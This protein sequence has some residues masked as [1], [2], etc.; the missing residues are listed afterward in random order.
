MLLLAPIVSSEGQIGKFEGIVVDSETDQRL[1]GATVRLKNS[2]ESVLTNQKGE[3]SLRVPF[4]RHDIEVTSPFYTSKTLTGIQVTEAQPTQII[5]VSLVPQIIPLAEIRVPIRFLQSSEVGM[6]DKRRRSRL[7]T[8]SMS[9]QWMSKISASD[10]GD[11]L[12]RVTGITIVGGRY[13]YVR[14]LGE[15]YSNTLLNNVEIPSPE[16]NRRVVPMDIFSANLLESIETVKTFSPDQPGSFSGGSVRIVTKEFPEALMMS[17]SA[18]MSTNTETTRKEALGSP[19]GSRDF[20]GFD[21]GSRAIPQLIQSHAKDTPI[22]ERGLFTQSG[23]TAEEIQRFGRSFR[24]VWSPQT[25]TVPVNQGYKFSIGN[26]ARLAGREFG[27]LGVLSYDNG[28]SHRVEERNTFRLGLGA[29]GKQALSP[30]TAYTVERSTNEIGWGGLL[31]TSIRLSPA[32]KV[33]LKT[34]YSHSAEDE[35]RTWE[36]FNSDRN[37]DMRSSRLLYIQRGLFSGQLSGEHD[38]MMGRPEG[39]SSNLTWRAVFSRATRDEPDTREVVYEERNGKWVFRD[40]TQSGSRFFFDLADDEFSGLIDWTIPFGSDATFKT[41]GLWRNKERQFDARRFRFQPA[42]NIDPFVDLSQPPEVIFAPENIAPRRFELRESTRATDNYRA[43]H[44]MWAGYAMLDMPL[45]K[46]WSV[47]T[48]ARLEASKQ[49]VTT[50]DPFSPGAV[51]IVAELKVTDILPSLNLTYRLTKGANLR[52]AASRTLARPDLREMAPFE[53]TDFIGGRTELGNPE[54]ERTWI[55]NYDLRLEVF[56][57]L[58]ELMAI[59][60]FY[61]KFHKPIEQVVQPAAEVRITYEN[62]KAANNFGVEMEL[63]QRL[64]VLHRHL[65][66]FSINTNLAFVSS[67]VVLPE[68]GVQTSSER[69]LQ[70]QSPFVVN[71]TLGYDNPDWGTAATLS[72]HVFGRRIAEVGN[73]GIPD[74]YELP[75][76]QLDA[77]LGRQLYS[78]LRVSIAAKNLLDPD[79]TFEQGDKTYLRYRTGRSFSFNVSYDF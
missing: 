35:A 1:A 69:S 61:K 50:F 33:S 71:A 14:G 2:D 51:P 45:A 37:T 65:R 67:K 8:D 27:Y 75:R 29:D 41:G 59:S 48:G 11:A 10:A 68:V 26:T 6:W 49:N 23:F 56:P 7:I 73:H 31:N 70:G 25:E 43:S 58:G 60:G 4:G 21:D 5:R 13:V 63:Q 46:R 78:Y 42:D 17:L 16:P 55:D 54:L 53:F 40:M 24:N 34:I 20:L 32:H 47:V 66:Y 74:V 38:F 76:S 39:R 15:R 19:G 77:T 36:G 3:F 9:E 52:L 44:D 64:D 30:F 72:Y 22:R 62:A 18:S 57:R 12:K 28:H 79:V